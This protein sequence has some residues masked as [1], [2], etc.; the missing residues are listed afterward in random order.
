[1]SLAGLETLLAFII[2]LG[3]AVLVHELGHF[4]AAKAFGVR[5]LEFAFGFPPKLFTLFRR[6]GTEYNVCALPIG[7]YVRLAGTEPGEDAGPDGFN[8]K[9]PW[10]RILVYFAGPLMNFILAGVL[11]V[12]LGMTVGVPTKGKEVLISAV[13]PGEPAALAGFREGDRVVAIDD[14]RITELDTML[15]KVKASPNRPILVT[16]ERDGRQMQIEVVPAAK[17]GGIGQIGVALSDVTYEKTGVIGAI[18]HGTEQTWR[19]TRDT[20]KGIAQVFT[21]SE[22]RKSVGGPVAIARLAGMA[23]RDGAITFLTFL[24]VISVNLGVLNLLPL[25]VVDGGQIAFLALEWVRGRRLQPSLQVSIQVVGMVI[26]LLFVALLTVR[27][28]TNWVGGKF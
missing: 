14:E 7:G 4:L 8:S 16:V 17:E 20:V 13:V 6:N 22:A 15:K 3:L 19:W 9:P 12:G 26:I 2:V 23:F 5:V 25:L 24:A 21:D 28:I 1:M 10:Q 11:F 27:D 18:A